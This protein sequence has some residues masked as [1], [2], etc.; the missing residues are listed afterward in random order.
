VE[1]KFLVELTSE[2]VLAKEC[3]QTSD[4]YHGELLGR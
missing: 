2:L 3:A 4:P 1:G